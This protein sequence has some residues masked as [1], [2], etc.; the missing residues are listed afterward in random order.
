[1]QSRPNTCRAVQVAQRPW[2]DHLPTAPVGQHARWQRGGPGV[3]M[4]TSTVISPGRLGIYPYHGSSIRI[5]QPPPPPFPQ[6]SRKVVPGTRAYLGYASRCRRDSHRC[7]EVAD[8]VRRRRRSHVVR[9]EKNIGLWRTDNGKMGGEKWNHPIV[10]V[11][12]RRQP[13]SRQSS[14]DPDP[15]NVECQKRG[16]Y[17]RVRVPRDKRPLSAW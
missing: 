17:R 4:C 3:C 11:I 1:M 12:A 9:P 13:F 15:A 16:R 5:A 14:G 7:S 8:L 10:S 2:L 6:L